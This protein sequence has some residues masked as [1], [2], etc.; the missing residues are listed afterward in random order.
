MMTYVSDIKVTTAP[1]RAP[2]GLTSVVLSS[3]LCHLVCKLEI[4]W[5]TLAVTFF[6]NVSKNQKRAPNSML[7]EYISLKKPFC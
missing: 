5:L 7:C 6:R 1:A 2:T 4:Y 3:F